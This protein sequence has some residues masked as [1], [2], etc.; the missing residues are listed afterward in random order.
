M[1]KADRQTSTIFFCNDKHKA[2]NVS[3]LDYIQF[4]WVFYGGIQDV[5]QVDWE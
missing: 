2:M 1:Q 5:Y 4:I 3:H